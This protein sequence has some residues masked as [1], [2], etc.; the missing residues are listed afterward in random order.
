M[1]DSQHTE[2]QA[3]SSVLFSKTARTIFFALVLA[4]LLDRF[5]PFESLHFLPDD[6]SSLVPA[7]FLPQSELEKEI[8]PIDESALLAMETVKLEQPVEIATNSVTPAKIE[9]IAA[10]APEVEAPVFEFHPDQLPEPPQP[11]ILENGMTWMP[12]EDPMN[13]MHRFYAALANTEA[14]RAR[15]ETDN[16]LA[17]THIVHYGDS[18]LA[19]DYVTS[20]LRRLLQTRF[21]DAGHGFILAGKPAPW[22]RHE[23]LGLYTSEGW[24]IYRLTSNHIADGWYGLGGAT[25]K[26]SNPGET[27]RIKPTGDDLGQSVQRFQVFYTAQPQG[28]KF[29]MSVDKRSV[30]VSTR[31]SKKA[32]R[33]AE[34]QVEDGAHE[35]RVKT[36]GAGEVRLFGVA[37]ERNTPGVVYDSL[38]MD[39]ARAKHL[40]NMNAEHWHDQIRLREPDIIILQ[41]GTNESQFENLDNDLYQANLAQTV[42]HLRQALPGVSCLLVGPMDRAQSKNG[43]LVTRESIK[44]IIEAQRRIALQQGCAFWNTFEAMGG[45]GSMANWYRQGLGGGDLT[46][47]TRKGADHIGQMLFLALLQ[48]YARR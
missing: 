47:P 20:T 1:A 44:P 19:S 21:G 23:Q 22:Y 5:T 37:L 3:K 39:G 27:I 30:E 43:K 38:G 17:Q 16:R 41:Y 12:I 26:T 36:L 9:E 24:N 14:A 32:S 8:A 7:A 31:L 42:G 6:L 2:N 18:L 48:G 29:E 34:I 15:G 46:H 40:K 4:V 35:L 13:A 10:R 25:F 11:Q 45:E 33:I 28:G